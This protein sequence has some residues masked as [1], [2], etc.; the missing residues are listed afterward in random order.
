MSLSVP[1]VA[2]VPAVVVPAAPPSE[3]ASDLSALSRAA[4]VN[5]V[6]EWQAA[7]AAADVG[8]AEASAA[9]A[10]AEAAAA[11]ASA[12]AAAAAASVP[13]PVEVVGGWIGRRPMGTIAGEPAADGMAAPPRP[14]IDGGSWSVAQA[15]MPLQ[16]V[17]ATSSVSHSASRGGDVG[18]GGG[19]GGDSG[20]GGGGG[21][22][23]D[24]VSASARLVPG[25][26]LRSMRTKRSIS[27]P[28]LLQAAIALLPPAS[29]NGVGVHGPGGGGAGGGGDEVVD[30]GWGG[31][32][33]TR[34]SS[35]HTHTRH[36]EE[37]AEAAE[38][39]EPPGAPPSWVSGGMGGWDSRSINPTPA[40]GGRPPP[41]VRGTGGTG[42]TVRLGDM[43]RGIRRRWRAFRSL[44]ASGDGVDGAD[45]AG[46]SGRGGGDGDAGTGGGSSLGGKHASGNLGA[47]A[48]S[49]VAAPIALLPSDVAVGSLAGLS[50]EYV[51]FR[52]VMPPAL[53]MAELVAAATEQGFRVSRVAAETGRLR[54]VRPRGTTAGGGSM[55]MGVRV[56][57]VAETAVV[58]VIKRSRAD[59]RLTPWAEY[60]AVYEAAMR[61]LSRVRPGCVIAGGGRGAGA[62]TPV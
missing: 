50:G 28:E 43:R 3:A 39:P 31:G 42:A 55:H 49:V 18:G 51:H 56:V 45:G 27:S 34:R 53:A 20:G 14:S 48:A 6:L 35:H 62:Y 58:V 26:R 8:V 41:T 24:L 15:P 37:A 5:R 44:F 57:S 40:A 22:G 12:A 46:G 25:N 4:G 2:P 29:A 13:P 33:P 10:A 61:R 60:V 54:A 59:G 32:P 17:E 19:T 38:T 11:T 21:G 36:E 47:A 30:L 23:G 9:A 52:L 7:L 1:I 16:A